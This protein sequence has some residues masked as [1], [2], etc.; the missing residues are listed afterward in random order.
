[1]AARK[2]ASKS[3]PCQDEFAR[4][5]QRILDLPIAHRVNE[6]GGYGPN[7]EVIYE[8]HPANCPS[9]LVDSRPD[10]S[11]TFMSNGSVGFNVKLAEGMD[12]AVLDGS[13]DMSDKRETRVPSQNVWLD[14][15]VG[16]AHHVASLMNPSINVNSP[17][18]S[19]R[20]VKLGD[21]DRAMWY[22]ARFAPA[23]GV[24][25]EAAI[26][27][28]F[29]CTPQGPA[30]LREIFVRNSGK[31]LLAGVLWTYLNLHGTQ[32][33]V[34][35]K[36][37]WYDS[38]LPI[39]GRE[40]VV[41]ATVPYSAILQA[42]R[43]S[44]LP[45][46]LRFVDATCDYLT[47]VG[48]TSAPAVLPQAVLA[49]KMLAG[50]AGRKLNRFSA[51]TIAAS[52][53]ALRLAPGQTASLQQSLLYVTD[54]ALLEQFRT[55][56]ACPAPGYKEVSAKFLTAAKGLI[57]G[58][59]GV[60]ECLAGKVAAAAQ[61]RAP[62]FEVALPGQPTISAYANS[63][64]IG[65]TELYENCR[66]HGAKLANGI[67]L[68]T[69]DRAQDMWPKLKE[70]PGRVRAD[71]VHAMSMMYQTCDQTPAVTPGRPMTFREKLHG[72]FP[73]QYPSRWDD[74][75][76]EIFN[77]NRPYNDSAT[78]FVNSTNMYIRETGDASILNERVRSVRLTSP[79]TP[80]KSGLVGCENSFTVAEVMIE[81]ME[82]LRRHATDS[83][84]GVVQVLY[85]DWCDPLDMYGT[86]A[87]GDPTTRG[88]GRGVHLRLTGHVFLTLVETIDQF[89]S[90]KVARLL[91]AKLL[92][93]VEALKA[94]AGELR[95]NMVR[96]AWEDGANAGFI[97]MIH[98][99]SA[100][101]SRPNYAAGQI[102]Y[103]LGSM[104]GRDADGVNRRDLA[105]QAYGL[106][107][108]MTDRDYLAP[109]ADRDTRVATLL[110]T[111]NELFYRPKLG[112]PLFSTPFAN[113]KLTRDLVGR[114]GILPAGCA[115]NGEYHHGQVMM[116]RY[117]LDVPGQ[118]DVAWRQFRP[119]MTVTRDKS[120]GGPFETPC[121]SYASDPNDPHFGK[122]MYFGLSGQV[123]WIIEIYQKIAGLELNLHDPRRPAVA[124]NPTLPAEMKDAF[125]FRRVV[126]YATGPGQYRQIPVTIAIRREGKGARLVETRTSLNGKPVARAEVTDLSGVTKLEFEIVRVYGK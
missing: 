97:G 41:A 111:V 89:A 61:E 88:H 103:T 55:D 96:V 121:T 124:V 78:W 46:N 17:A 109:V 35:N 60:A 4:Q 126:H 5:A 40:T 70:D 74:R 73:R 15:A 118:A 86:G 1:M 108:L 59:P 3:V 38:G 71:L 77:D 75:R 65:V 110:K 125:T 123:D 34:Y 81:V 94:F 8:A 18:A 24:K 66:A 42:K 58:T 57:A 16:K 31:S 82:C 10:A 45:G 116:H 115:E 100:D 13:W 101:G 72:M 112:L 43:V 36:D 90:P 21:P 6:L 47:F 20:I 68:G 102:G 7:L 79:D 63:V 87:V 49:G 114:M 22:C 91:D 11:A 76:Q 14:V 32:R 48:D 44:S 106:A 122:G 33:F 113:S 53:F 80:E 2:S 92:A 19:I 28:S 119:I 93:R 105:T 50:G 39:D 107:M 51:P 117:R 83:P 37:L 62:Y 120:V 54:A 23:K 99:L 69:R 30:V 98:E 64:W 9:V 85:G 56:S 26:K 29:A 25:Y 84:Y 27:F 95:Q 67:E 104:K 12:V 52:Q